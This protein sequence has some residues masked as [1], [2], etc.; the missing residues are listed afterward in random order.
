MYGTIKAHKP[1]KQYPMRLVVSTIGT[2][3][4][5]ISAYL[6]KIIQH[7]LNKNPRRLKNSASFVEKAKTWSISPTE[8]QVS[9]DVVNLY[10]SVPLKEA[11]KVILD[12]LKGD[13]SYSNYTKLR[14]N[15]IKEMIELCISRC[16]FIWNEEIHVLKD[17]GPIG[18]SI[19]VVLAEGFLQVL[20]S[21]AL[22]EALR[23]QPPY[24]P[25]TFYRYV[26]DSYSRFYEITQPGRKKSLTI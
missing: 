22:D 21:K 12:L 20:E 25:I 17:S 6:V 24:A 18:L 2:P 1:E 5:G 16:Y 10:P 11:T 26:D 8:V 23:E 9:F 7:T 13:P 4:H 14:L 3:P 19:M 15:E